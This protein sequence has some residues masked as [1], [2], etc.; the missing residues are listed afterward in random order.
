MVDVIAAGDTLLEGSVIQDVADRGLEARVFQEVFYV[1]RA[2]GRQVIQDVNG[3]S[4]RNQV[5]GQMTTDEPSAS[6]NKT[7]HVPY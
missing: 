3:M 2:S 7:S 4:S 1:F 6:G 5:V